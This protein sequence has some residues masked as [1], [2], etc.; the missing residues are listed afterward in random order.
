[1]FCVWIKPPI[2][3]RLYLNPANKKDYQLYTMHSLSANADSPD[4]L[5]F[6]LLSLK[7]NIMVMFYRP[8]TKWK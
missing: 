8:L 1:M 2:C 5:K 4:K 7:N 3:H 6:K